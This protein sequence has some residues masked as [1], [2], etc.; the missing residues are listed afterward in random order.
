[1]GD[2]DKAEEYAQRGLRREEAVVRP[3]CLYVLGGVRRAQG[4]LGEA[5]RF[6]REAITVGEELQ[7]P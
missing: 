1:L 4:R 6:G 2:L 5:E 3:Y 7:D